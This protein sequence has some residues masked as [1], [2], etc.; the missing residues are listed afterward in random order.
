MSNHSTRSKELFLVSILG[1]LLGGTA[2]LL[3]LSKEG[4]K[5]INNIE[6]TYEKVKENFTWDKQIE[7]TKKIIEE[8]LGKK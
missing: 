3:L 1:V 6:G 8:S 5:L 4:K 7:K 2:T